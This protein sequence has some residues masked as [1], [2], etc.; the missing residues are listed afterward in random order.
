MWRHVAAG[1]AVWRHLSPQNAT[2]RHVAENLQMNVF[3]SKQN[4]TNK[5]KRNLLILE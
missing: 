5:T 3:R 4:K 2:I 1:S